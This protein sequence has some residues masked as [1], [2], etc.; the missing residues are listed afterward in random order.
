M[1]T[2]TFDHNSNKVLLHECV[3][4]MAIVESFPAAQD[5]GESF[6]ILSKVRSL[7]RALDTSAVYEEDSWNEVVGQDGGDQH[8]SPSVR[9]LSPDGDLPEKLKMKERRPKS[10]ALNL[11]DYGDGLRMG[12]NAKVL[13]ILARNSEHLK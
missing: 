1:C 13:S 9:S 8:K 7:K 2:D 3:Y 12:D 6:E 10:V 4:A 5:I 11:L